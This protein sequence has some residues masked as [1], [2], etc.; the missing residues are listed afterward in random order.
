[1]IRLGDELKQ[2]KSL[3][4]KLT[5]ELEAKRTCCCQI[6]FPS[7]R[8]L[9]THLEVNQPTRSTRKRSVQP[10][11]PAS[12]SDIRPA[13]RTR[14]GN[15]ESSKS[16][17]LPPLPPLPPLPEGPLFR[18]PSQQRRVEVL[19]T[20]TTS[21]S[22]DKPLLSLVEGPSNPARTDRHFSPS[23]PSPLSSYSERA[24]TALTPL[25]YPPVVPALQVAASSYKLVNPYPSEAIKVTPAPSQAMS[26]SSPARSPQQA[27]LQPPVYPQAL[28]LLSTITPMINSYPDDSVDRYEP[29]RRR[30]NANSSLAMPIPR[31]PAD[32]SL[33]LK[34]E[35][36]DIPIPS[37]VPPR[38]RHIAHFDYVYEGQW[39]RISE[40]LRG[41]LL[42][43]FASITE[44]DRQ[45]SELAEVSIR[46]SIDASQAL[47]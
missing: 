2:C 22:L 35:S 24:T 1:M 10:S 13:K 34:Q 8:A 36:S 7:T 33:L 6:A 15:P 28:L 27:I 44:P 5:S 42:D 14:S 47:R 16:T 37:S 38:V 21:P 40:E 31:A 17:S 46:L 29:T 12:S 19:Q 18:D 25:L 23:S 9:C 43:F 20:P 30:P 11:A 3:S 45:L 32:Y 26:D 4:R 39:K 41:R